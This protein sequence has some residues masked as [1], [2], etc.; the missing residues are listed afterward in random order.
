MGE[1]RSSV[2]Q[3]SNEQGDASPEV[4]SLLGAVFRAL[5][6]G[7]GPKAIGAAVGAL[8]TIQSLK[9]EASQ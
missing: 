3:V 2:K 8:F 6:N 5:S 9:S 4:R 7:P 1:P